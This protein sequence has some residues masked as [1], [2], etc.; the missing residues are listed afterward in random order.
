MITSVSSTQL[1]RAKQPKDRLSKKKMAV[2]VL[3]PEFTH[4]RRGGEEAKL[5][6]HSRACEQST[7]V[8]DHKSSIDSPLTRPIILLVNFIESLG[9]SSP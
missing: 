1:P 2:S 7:N 6:K 4:R 9:S 3:A 8:V 5:R